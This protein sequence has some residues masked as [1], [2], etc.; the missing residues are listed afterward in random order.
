MKNL[1]CRAIKPLTVTCYSLKSITGFLKVL[2]VCVRDKTHPMA[3]ETGEEVQIFE[4]SE[5]ISSIQKDSAGVA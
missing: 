4:V 3:G 1:K 5:C 2:W